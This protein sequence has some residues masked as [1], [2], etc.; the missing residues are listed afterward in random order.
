MRS[1]K[2]NPELKREGSMITGKIKKRGGSPEVIRVIIAGTEV[3]RRI[4]GKIEKAAGDGIGRVRDHQKRIEVKSLDITT[5]RQEG[6]GRD[7]PR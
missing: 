5:D 7:H 1:L 4:E 3:F 2:R 6:R